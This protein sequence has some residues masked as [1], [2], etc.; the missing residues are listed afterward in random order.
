MFEMVG[1]VSHGTYE[2]DKTEHIQANQRK[3]QIIDQMKRITFRITIP[4]KSGRKKQ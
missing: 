1:L 3:K 4:T 2:K